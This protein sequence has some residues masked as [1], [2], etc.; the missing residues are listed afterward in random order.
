[1]LG[2]VGREQNGQVDAGG[3]VEVDKREVGVQLGLAHLAGGELHEPVANADERNDKVH[4][5]R[6]VVSQGHRPGDPV[7]HVVRRLHRR[8]EWMRHQHQRPKQVQSV[9]TKYTSAA[10]ISSCS[11]GT[12][13]S[14]S[15]RPTGVR[16]L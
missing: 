15:R 9:S 2:R 13:R 10:R 6:Q 7:L 14:L 5:G 11:D 8:M 3:E 16:A 12:D 4:L 1:M